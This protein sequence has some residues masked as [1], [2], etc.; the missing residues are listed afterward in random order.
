MAK[1]WGGRFSGATDP[2]MEAFNASIGFDRKL[3]EVDIQGSQAYARAIERQGII[4]GA[5]SKE[6]Q[7]GLGRVLEEVGGRRGVAAC[8]TDGH[9]ADV[10]NL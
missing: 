8:A 10:C 4:T 5:E 6:I 9:P 1:L 3:F 7:D 2:V